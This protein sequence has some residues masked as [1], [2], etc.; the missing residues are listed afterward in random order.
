MVRGPKPCIE[1]LP[2]ISSLLCTAPLVLPLMVVLPLWPPLLLAVLTDIGRAALAVE[3]AAAGEAAVGVASR[4]CLALPSL[5][6]LPLPSAAR[7]RV[8]P[9]GGCYR[10]TERGH[11]GKGVSGHSLPVESN[12]GQILGYSEW[13]ISTVCPTIRLLLCTADPV[14]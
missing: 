2:I 13:L 9:C 7:L 3:R 14:N 12:D 11:A 5:F 1:L 8:W 6:G 10:Q 4:R